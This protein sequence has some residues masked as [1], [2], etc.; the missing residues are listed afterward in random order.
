MVDFPNSP[1]EDQQHVEEG[2]TWVFNNGRW[3]VDAVTPPTGV[4]V[5][6]AG[7]T[8]TGNLAVP[9]LSLPALSSDFWLN[10]IASGF[11]GSDPIINFRSNAYIGH[12]ATGDRIEIGTKPVRITNGTLSFGAS[13][14]MSITAD[15]T[16][17]ALNLATARALRYRIANGNIELVGNVD[18][19]EIWR[20]DQASNVIVTSI[21]DHRNNDVYMQGSAASPT[22]SRNIQYFTDGRVGYTAF[23][24]TLHTPGVHLDY[25]I[26]LDHSAPAIFSFRS[27]G[28]AFSAGGWILTSD[29]R[30]KTDIV[31]IN[32]ALSKLDQLSGLVFTRTDMNDMRL[33]GITAQALQRVLPEAVFDNDDTLSIDPMGAIALLVE[34]VKELRSEVQQMK[35]NTP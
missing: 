4:Y 19:R 8:M 7:D 26:V 32:N 9:Q 12:R 10:P 31:S 13:G 1:I 20:Y 25:R 16:F 35:A 11:G 29:E 27:T 21:L 28:Q 24:D 22:Q 17:H 3:H 18:G 5:T 14:Q 2:V 34:A 15:G 33:A 6:R 30:K 23:T